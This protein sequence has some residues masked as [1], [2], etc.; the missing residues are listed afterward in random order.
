MKTE[1]THLILDKD[2]HRR[3]KE[4]AKPQTVAAYLREL[5]L[6]KETI[7]NRLAVLS[8]NLATLN[9]QIQCMIEASKR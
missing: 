8:N 5:S 9:S 2:T 3:F 7:E 1:R 6:G 4:L